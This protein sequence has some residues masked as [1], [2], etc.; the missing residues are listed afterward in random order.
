MEPD[1]LTPATYITATVHSLWDNLPR[2]VVAGLWFSLLAAPAFVLSVLGWLGPALLAGLLL[3]GP[4]WV[5]LLAWEAEL[6]GGRLPSFAALWQG[7]LRLWW[8]SVRLGVLALFLLTLVHLWST[9]LPL[10]APAWLAGLTLLAWLYVL[11][12]L[13]LCLVAIAPALAHHH[14]DLPTALRDG[15]VAA[16]RYPS[17]TVGLVALF[18]LFSLAI[19]NLSGGLIF[20]LPAIVGLFVANNWRLVLMLERERA[21]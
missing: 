1:A 19:I 15:F 16:S 7:W 3:V 11:L 4:G 13:A 8:S 20:F 12:W 17:H 14:G 18:V 6:L 21:V 10:D 9:H 5:A 2:V